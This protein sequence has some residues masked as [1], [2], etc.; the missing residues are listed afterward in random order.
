MKIY[1]KCRLQTVISHWWVCSAGNTNQTAGKTL[2]AQYS[3]CIVGMLELGLFEDLY[4][5]FGGR[6]C[7]FLDN[8]LHSN[9]KFLFLFV[10]T[11]THCLTHTHYAQKKNL[12]LHIYTS[13]QN[14]WAFQNATVSSRH[15]NYILEVS[16]VTSMVSPLSAAMAPSDCLDAFF[17]VSVF[18]FFCLRPS[19]CRSSNCSMCWY[20]THT[21]ELWNAWYNNRRRIWTKSIL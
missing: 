6:P 15:Y 17:L 18:F 3:Y 21:F 16:S 11:A 12:H 8:I 5:S 7:W 13:E 2:L 19:A 20:C 10:R 9:N 1:H 4:S 14:G